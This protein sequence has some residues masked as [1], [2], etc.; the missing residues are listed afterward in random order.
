MKHGFFALTCLT[1]AACLAMVVDGGFPV[2][3]NSLPNLAREGT[4]NASATWPDPA[5]TA[6]MGNDG[7]L[8]T[9]WS[10]L[11]SGSEWYE[12]DWT[13]SQT[14][15]AIA[16]YYQS[17]ASTQ[18]IVQAWNSLTG[19][20][21]DVS[22]MPAT[23]SKMNFYFPRVT[24]TRLRLQNVV[25]FWEAE[26]YNFNSS[27]TPWYD[28]LPRIVDPA[29]PQTVSTYA[30]NAAIGV[31]FDPGWSLWFTQAGASADVQRRQSLDSI[32]VRSIGYNEGFGTSYSPVCEIGAGAPAS[33][34]NMYWSWANYGGGTVKWAGDWTWFDD[35]DFAR[36]YTRTGIYS[37][38]PMTYPNGTVA[39]GFIDNDSSDPRRSRVY[40][41]GCSKDIFGNIQT[42]YSYVAIGPT[43]GLL[44]ISA[45]GQYAGLVYFSKDTAC[46]H[47]AESAAVSTRYG[48]L[49]IG[50]NGVWTDNMSSWDS[51]NSCPLTAGFGE[52]S[53]AG[54]RAYLQKYFTVD[55]LISYGVIPPGGSYSN[56]NSFDIR[57]FLR[58]LASSK[59]G[60]NG[61]D[62]SSASWRNAGWV[63]EPVWRAYE[64][65]KRQVGTQ[66]LANYCT[67]VKAAASAAGQPDF[68]LMGNDGGPALLGWM[69]G[70]IDMYS[71]ELGL[72]WDPNGGSRGFGLPPF[73]RLSPYYKFVRE[74]AASRFVNIW[75]Y[76][77]SYENQLALDPVVNA[78]YYEMLATH[79]M[80]KVPA[81]SVSYMAGNTF[82]DKAF[83]QFV[84]DAAQ[85]EFGKR[86][87]VEDIGIYCS[88]SSLL[89]KCTP[90][91]ALLYNV[92]DPHM[93]ALWGWGT[94]LNELHYQFRMIP[95]WKLTQNVLRT[96]KVLIIPNSTVFDSA[97]AAMLDN[98]VRN[99]GGLLIVTGDSGSRLG[100]GHNFEMSG[101]L[102][103]ASLTGVSN[104]STAPSSNTQ[105]LGNG[106]VRYLKSNIGQT[107]YDATASG[108]AS[109]LATFSSEMSSILSQSGQHAC[110]LSVN[111]PASA[112]ITLYQD[113]VARR[114]FVD[115][116]NMNVNIAADGLSAS[117]TPTPQINVTVYK[118]SWWNAYGNELV[119]C[120]IS[121]TGTVSLPTPTTYSD[122]ID[123]TIPSTTY[124]TSVILSP[125]LPISGAK[126]I[127]DGNAA[128]L[129]GQIVSA[130]F[131]DCFYVEK[132]DR[133]SG[134]RVA[135]S[136]DAVSAGSVVSVAGI[137]TTTSDGERFLNASD[138]VGHG[139][140]SV[141]PLGMTV[142]SLGGGDLVYTSNGSPAIA[143]IGV[144]EGH[145]LNNI[146]LLV[147]ICGTV[148]GVGDGFFCISDG[149]D[150]IDASGFAGARVLAG[151]LG[152]PDPGTFVCVTGIS[153]LRLIN[154]NYCRCIRPRSQ[155]DILRNEKYTPIGQW[156]FEGVSPLANKSQACTWDTLTLN[157]TGAEVS[158]GKLVLPRYLSGSWKQCSATTMLKT[159]LGSSG[160][161]KDLTI[162]AW[163]DW[164]GFDANYYGRIAGLFK[165]STSSYNL[166]NLTAA[167]S[168]LY[169]G[170]SGQKWRSY[171]TW[172]TGYEYVDP[173]AST[174]VP[175][176]DRT[177]KIAQVLKQR[178][179]GNSDLTMYWD[180]GSGLVQLGSSKTVLAANVESFGQFGTNCIS[181]HATGLRYDG[182][183]IMDS[184]TR[185][186]STA[187]SI[188][189]EEIRLYGAAL[190]SDE[191][192]ELD[193]M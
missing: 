30:A 24:T 131:D 140:G 87:P 52:W 152:M 12:I 95:E 6:S 49:E 128:L 39:T 101:S 156:D 147:K 141:T 122:R 53:V 133:T 10:G 58:S 88:T 175:P 94:A 171:R 26:V 35:A 33:L 98:W 40:D 63:D 62:L 55:Q 182:F 114:I 107:F 8:A 81:P 191:I 144:D 38:F 113:P 56:L 14:F 164:P 97:D 121:P 18:I 31:G 71:C 92:D 142:C 104:Y 28:V 134:L 177:F 153:T 74:G 57:A 181:G 59:Y 22:S 110:L 117:V 116:N 127:S 176:A 157:G 174:A 43:T 54:F 42:D 170:Y 79:T 155:S 148:T 99:D 15:N 68:F 154:G 78:I 161:F 25:S 32:G 44:Y 189:I 84:E 160:Y 86:V 109:Q 5:Y 179:D 37:G 162:V 108:R 80:P 115:V 70:S 77:R 138:V 50:I 112:G 4:A 186:P 21:E 65:Y 46:P 48:V 159:D 47:W 166:Y 69:R 96:L 184:M 7:N 163:V 73:E 167:Q 149:S 172:E 9:R 139:Q 120:A 102:T 125:A 119:A 193:F 83:L 13:T 103:L 132:P 20:F 89:S 165:F 60:W 34:L 41:A 185:V 190:T 158:G 23:A 111:A 106:R 75:L 169:G 129:D 118:P 126:K 76:N 66:A 130:V 16:L 145:G 64:I 61:S 143:Q 178:T 27:S 188:C 137:M 85:P 105:V 93:H 183:G 67:S 3:A 90:G 151:G 173:G 180:T 36:P 2:Y 82:A 11:G 29:D 168:I 19:R 51:F 136:G 1:L 45:A 72:D 150:V 187:G 192:S 124:Y 100:E 146:G 91:G 17:I 123:V 135:Y